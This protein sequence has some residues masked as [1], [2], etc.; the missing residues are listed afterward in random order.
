MSQIAFPR[1]DQSILARRDAIVAAPRGDPAR[2]MSDR[3]RIGPAR[4]RDRRADRLSPLPLAVVL[5]R[6]TEEVARVLRFC[7]DEKVNVVPRGAGTSLSGGAIPQED[8]VVIGLTK[9]SRILE[10]NL[11]DRYARVE[12]GVTNL[13]ISEAVGA[14]GLLLRARSVLAARLHDRRQYRR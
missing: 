14:G 13:A 9:M 3:R 5:P 1:L 11:A 12:A 8:A 7:R 4:V 6:S 2:R 10:I